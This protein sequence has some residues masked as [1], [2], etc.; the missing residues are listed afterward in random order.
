MHYETFPEFSERHG[1]NCVRIGEDNFFV[2]A[3]G[4]AVRDHGMSYLL[5]SEPSPDSPEC[6]GNKKSYWS[7]RVQ[8]AEKDFTILRTSLLGGTISG[9]TLPG[10][11]VW[12]QKE[13]GPPPQYRDGTEALSHLRSIV[14][15][16]RAELKIITDAIYDLPESAILRA[17]EAREEKWRQEEWQRQSAIRETVEKI[18]I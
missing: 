11:C 1:G 13:Y 14:T 5:F 16:R 2:F 9:Q 7:V 3:D 8:R 18:E 17:Q 12:N 15:E 6:L 10:Q 4:S